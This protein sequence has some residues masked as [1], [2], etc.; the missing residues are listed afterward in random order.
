M[1]ASVQI[2]AV[3]AP[4]RR[5]PESNFGYTRAPGPPS[6]VHRACPIYFL[7]P[8]SFRRCAFEALKRKMPSRGMPESRLVDVRVSAPHD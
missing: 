2:S 7:G 1:P 4:E 6:R 5:P 8:S 3:C